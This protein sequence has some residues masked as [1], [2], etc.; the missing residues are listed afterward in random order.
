MTTS[1]A[2]AGGFANFHNS[3]VTLSPLSVTEPTW[4]SATVDHTT[5]STVVL[6]CTSTPTI[7]SEFG[8]EST[9][10]ENSNVAVSAAAELVL[11]IAICASVAETQRGTTATICMAL[12]TAALIPPIG[13]LRLAR[14]RQQRDKGRAM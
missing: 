7:N 13:D 9:L 14:V 4:V 8:P 3:T 11:S 1:P 12:K 5:L 10:W 6:A 2:P